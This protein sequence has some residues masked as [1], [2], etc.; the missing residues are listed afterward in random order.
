M[1]PSQCFP[2]EAKQGRAGAP[3]LLLIDGEPRSP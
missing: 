3:H 1:S 2:K